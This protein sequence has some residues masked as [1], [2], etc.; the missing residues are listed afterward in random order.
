VNTCGIMLILISKEL[1]YQRLFN[2]T[3][4]TNSRRGDRK[5]KIFGCAIF[6][7]AELNKLI[8]TTIPPTECI[9]REISDANSGVG[10][11]A[12]HVL[13][14]ASAHKLRDRSGERI[15]VRVQG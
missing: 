9:G 10:E 1:A 8:K 6:V 3:S 2:D 12:S 14:D 15:R 4:S 11:F 7:F 5:M 13:A